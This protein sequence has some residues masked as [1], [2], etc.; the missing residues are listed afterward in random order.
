MSEI[1]IKR[2]R[3]RAIRAAIKCL[4]YPPG[5]YQVSKISNHVFHIEADREKESCK[6]RVV[7]D[8]IKKS[9][10]RLVLYAEVPDNC[11]KEIWCRKLNG[12]FDV[13]KI[14]NRFVKQKNLHL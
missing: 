6:I 3:R 5:R 1:A 2:R 10:E 14:K 11:T 9:D 8:E 12:Q 7:L 13:L 4:L